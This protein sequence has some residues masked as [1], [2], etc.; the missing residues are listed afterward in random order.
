MKSVL[1]P[2]KKKNALPCTVGID[3]ASKIHTSKIN[4]KKKEDKN[5]V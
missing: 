3:L 1:E 4:A 2:S 5:K